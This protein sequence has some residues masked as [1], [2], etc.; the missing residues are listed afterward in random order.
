METPY[1]F[2]HSNMFVVLV[3]PPGTKKSTAIRAGRK[4][5]KQ[6]GDAI[7]LSPDAPSV[8]GLMDAFKAIPQKDH[9]SLNAFIGEMSTLYENAKET[10]TGFLT[11]MYDGDPDYKKATRAGGGVEHIPYPWLNMIAATTPSWLGESMPKG[12]IEGGLVARTIYVYSE[13]ELV[14]PWPK[15]TSEL[16]I[17]EDAL[18]HD[19]AHISQLRGEF[20]F[21][22][23]E[24]G[25]A[26]QWYEHWRLDLTGRRPA[27]TDNRTAG[28]FSR[29]PIHLL[30]VAMAVSLS[31][32]NSLQLEVED[33]GVALALLKQ[34]EPG[35]IQAFSAVGNN[36]YATETERILRLIRL[37]PEG[38]TYGELVAATYHNMEQRFLDGALMSL[39]T[40]RKVIKGTTPDNQ[41][42]YKAR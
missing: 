1:F 28:Y 35:M 7:N 22:G 21:R 24:A 34:I 30:K 41:V 39:V 37:H 23:G 25:D 10:M 31:K 32:G 38:V 6:L 9:Q 19:L 2:A 4:L 20:G 27:V 36:I 3:G 8:V 11:H 16:R 5:L 26:F 40:M 13:E 12:A 17:L 33:L 18:V 29:K 42:A 14:K 15:Y